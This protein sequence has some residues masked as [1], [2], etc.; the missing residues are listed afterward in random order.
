MPKD[1]MHHTINDYINLNDKVNELDCFLTNDICFLP[2][3]LEETKS[4]SEF[5]YTDNTLTVKK[6]F[7]KNNLLSDTLEKENLN[8][9]QR[10]SIDWYAP[11]IYIGFSLL[12]QNPTLV[13]IALNVLSNYI[14][15]F[16]KGT[17]GE[18]KVKLDVVVEVTPKKTYKRISYEGNADGLKNLDKIIKS[19][20]K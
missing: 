11:T 14:T 6:L 16:F 20:K 1:N 18:K 10:R 7:N 4:K 3:N 9:R 15:D 8:L 13:S 17:F 19:L 2:E 12:T 5:I